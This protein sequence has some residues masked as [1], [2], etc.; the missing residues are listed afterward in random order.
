[1]LRREVRESGH[2]YVFSLSCSREN[3]AVKWVAKDHRFQ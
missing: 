3:N 1:M 2:V